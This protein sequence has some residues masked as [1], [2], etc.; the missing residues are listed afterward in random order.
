MRSPLVTTTSEI[1]MT[2]MR[3]L[4][5]PLVLHFIAVVPTLIVAVPDPL[6]NR[7]LMLKT[8]ST[9]AVESAIP[10]LIS[11]MP[12]RRRDP[13]VRLLLKL[14]LLAAG[15]AMAMARSVSSCRTMR[16]SLL[17]S[18]VK[19]KVAVYKLYLGRMVRMSW[20]SVATAAA[21][22]ALI[23]VSEAACEERGRP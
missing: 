8:T 21:G 9:Q 4:K 16:P 17:S 10:S 12:S 19:W 23:G 2:M 11:H 22:R 7:L 18:T 15:V 1:T 20:S 14:G 5:S 13:H 3:S 6:S